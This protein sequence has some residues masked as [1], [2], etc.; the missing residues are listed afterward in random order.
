[1][2][3]LMKISSDAGNVENKLKYNLK[4]D[5]HLFQFG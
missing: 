4:K 2:N 5:L 1:M 3:F